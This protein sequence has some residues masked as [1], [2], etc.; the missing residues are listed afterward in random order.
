MTVNRYYPA[1]LHFQN[2]DGEGIWPEPEITDGQRIYTETLGMNAGAVGGQR[3]HGM[4]R[5]K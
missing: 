5:W 4:K 1:H 2:R 3:K